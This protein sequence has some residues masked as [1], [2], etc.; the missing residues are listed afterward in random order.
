MSS[1]LSKAE[2]S[3]TTDEMRELRRYWDA[4]PIFTDSVPYAP[5]T[6]EFF[7]RKLLAHG[8]RD[9]QC[10]S[11]SFTAAGRGSGA[12]GSVWKDGN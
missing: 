6:R 1:F 11:G 10:P 5:G 8:F 2:M 12:P 7:L 9:V 3:V 4:H